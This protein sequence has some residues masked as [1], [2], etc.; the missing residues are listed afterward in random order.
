MDTE[1]YLAVEVEI[2]DY[3]NVVTTANPMYS[4]WEM[5]AVNSYTGETI[6]SGYVLGSSNQVKVN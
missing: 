2:G 5:S 3:G 4:R 6:S 1:N